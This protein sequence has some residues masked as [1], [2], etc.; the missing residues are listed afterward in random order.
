MGVLTRMKNSTSYIN[1]KNKILRK[2]NITSVVGLGYVGLPLAMAFASSRI[3]TI[4]YDVNQ[5]RVS[6][7]KKNKSY[8]SSVKNSLVKKTKRY[9]F[10]TSNIK[11]LRKSNII[12]IC[13]PTP[14]NDISKIPNLGYI[15]EVI[16]KLRT[17]DLSEKLIIFEC[18]SYPGTTEEVFLPLLKKKKLILGEKIFLGYSPEREDP[19]NPNFSLEKKNIPKVISGFTNKCQELTSLVYKQVTKKIIK[20]NNIKT[21]EFTKLLENIY[22]SIN[23]GLINELSEISK[24]FN[25]DINES[26]LAAKSKPFGFQPFYPGPGV[27]GHCIPVD[28]YYLSWKAKKLGMDSKFIKLA[29]RINDSRPNVIFN[30]IKKKIIK[31]NLP[32]KKILF[33]GLA[34]KKNCDDLRNSPILKIIQKFKDLKSKIYCHDPFIR[35]KEYPAVQK[36]INIEFKTLNEKNLKSADIVIIGTDHDK[37]NYS[38]I[39][40]YSSLV[41]DTRNV[42]KFSENNIIKL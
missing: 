11:D 31:N 38:L 36:L 13:V 15:K 33:I 40:K 27:G 12:I 37:I 23:I 25:I 30:N 41:F 34:Y 10:P 16:L 7:L 9:F 18:T 14:I 42:Y 29:G 24:K 39:K 5:G 28:P 22:R 21:A 17:I 26:I 2:K 32:Y 1:L 8:I 4:G 20:V 6:I 3:K 19:G 35:I